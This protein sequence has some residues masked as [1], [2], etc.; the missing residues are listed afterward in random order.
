MSNPRGGG[1]MLIMPAWL[2][3]RQRVY[4][5]VAWSCAA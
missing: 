4:Y 2:I 5:E 1:D 3:Y